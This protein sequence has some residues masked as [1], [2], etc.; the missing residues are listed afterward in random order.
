MKARTV[1]EYRGLKAMVEYAFFDKGVAGAC[2]T[3]Y[4]QV[5]V[6]KFRQERVRQSELRRWRQ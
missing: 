5:G 2:I 4:P 3:F 1:V 6:P